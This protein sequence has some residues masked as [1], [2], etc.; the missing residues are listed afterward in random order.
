MPKI[1]PMLT[2][3]QI[4]ALPKEG[5]FPI[6]PRLYIQRG[7]GNA[8][9]VFR[10]KSPITKK[11]RS[12]GLG[13]YEPGTI[14]AGQILDE[15]RAKAAVLDQKVKD[16]IDPIVERR[17]ENKA[18]DVRAVRRE[19]ADETFPQLVDK[20]AK[21]RHS[22]KRTARHWKAWL[23]SVETHAYP[24]FGEKPWREI[25]K[26]DVKA[27]LEPIWATK[28]VTA[29]R[30]RAR[31]EAVFEF[32][33]DDDV[34]PAPNPALLGHINIKLNE[35]AEHHS[36]VHFVPL[37]FDTVPTLMADLAKSDLMGAVALRLVI[38][39]ACRSD[40]A[41]QAVWGEIQGDLWVVSRS[42]MK[43]RDKKNAE[44]G[45]W[46]CPLS[47]PAIALLTALRPADARP[48]DF[49]FVGRNGCISHD[50]MLKILKAHGEK[51]VHGA[52]SVFKKWAD[53]NGWRDAGQ[54]QLDHIVKDPTEAA[55]S[56]TETL[57]DQ[58]KLVL[59]A[60]GSHCMP[61]GAGAVVDVP[62]DN[63]IVRLDQAR[64]QA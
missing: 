52:R 6:S 36:V 39:T 12:M 2:V 40:T 41:R 8:S 64:A 4:A 61:S 53:R 29:G 58:R 63:N 15:F 9:M 20:F 22:A 26:Q 43:S 18:Q 47:A 56:Q 3:R 35:A 25:T 44:R 30:V 27:M 1:A 50:R 62:N 11:G 32:G 45:P 59:A 24:A 17:A 38:L 23:A 48:D 13:R 54:F 16:G 28:T 37:N 34:E 42:R 51:H 5:T 49:V 14:N 60:W 46:E 31:C 19:T 55:Y 57:L 7:A 10:Y 33:L 21:A